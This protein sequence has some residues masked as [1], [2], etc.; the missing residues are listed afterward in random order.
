MNAWMVG[1][2]SRSKHTFSNAT[3]AARPVT[4]RASVLLRMQQLILRTSIVIF[5]R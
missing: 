1:C 2:A 3:T 5:D 4:A